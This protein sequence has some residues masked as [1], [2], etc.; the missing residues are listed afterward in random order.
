M[1][2]TPWP[3]ARGATP[4]EAT[5]ERPAWSA[6][7]LRCLLCVVV[8][9]VLPVKRE[10]NNGFVCKRHCSS[11]NTLFENLGPLLFQEDG[12]WARGGERENGDASI[13][14]NSIYCYSNSAT[15]MSFGYVRLAR[16]GVR[17]HPMGMH[18]P[19]F[20]LQMNRR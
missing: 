5:P 15:H 13:I 8:A 2:Q 3:V 18:A 4:T 10:A 6:D 20:A 16:K 7:V 1:E 12:I 11:A 14:H 9:Q 17:G 19:L